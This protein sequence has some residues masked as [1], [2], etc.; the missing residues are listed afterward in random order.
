MG[1]LIQ[2]FK[3]HRSQISPKPYLAKACSYIKHGGAYFQTCSDHRR[4]PRGFLSTERHPRRRHRPGD[5]PHSQPPPRPPLRPQDRHKGLAPRRPHLLRLFTPRQETIR[6]HRHNRQP[7]QR[8]RNIRDPALA[9]ELDVGKVDKIVEKG[10]RREV[11]MYSAFYDPLE[12]PRVSDSGLADVLREGGITHVYVVGLAF[13]YCV[14]ATAVDAQREGFKTVVVREGTRAVEKDGWARVERELESMG[15]GV[16][17][18]EGKE[19]QRVSELGG[20]GSKK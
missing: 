14:R 6:Q 16:V 15:V 20:K 9:P 13:D 18:V 4:S 17:G 10:M 5:N 12:K 1:K 7:L 8:L 2:A 11:E 19:V 3:Q